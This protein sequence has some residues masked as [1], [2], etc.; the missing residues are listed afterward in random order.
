MSKYT[1]IEI[2]TIS[3]SNGVKLIVI[4]RCIYIMPIFS[5]IAIE[6]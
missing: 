4:S 5:E 3:V 2:G 6:E 1:I